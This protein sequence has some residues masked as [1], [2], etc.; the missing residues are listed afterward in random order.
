[1]T[2]AS[3]ILSAMRARADHRLLLGLL[4]DR[5]EVVS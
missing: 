3:R 5:S 2:F 4:I 1:M